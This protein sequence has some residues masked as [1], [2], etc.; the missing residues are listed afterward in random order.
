MTLSIACKSIYSISNPL[1]R[2]LRVYSVALGQAPYGAPD[3]FSFFTTDF[4]PAGDHREAALISPEAE[5]LTMSTMVTTQ[6]A[7]YALVQFGLS[8]CDGGIGPHWGRGVNWS[9]GD[10][11]LSLKH[12]AGFLGFTPTGDLSSSSNVVDQ[13]ATILTAGRLSSTNRQLIEE[14]YSNVYSSAQGREKEALQV[15]QVLIITSP[16]FNTFN[17]VVTDHNKERTPTP[18]AEKD[19]NTEYK[20]IIHLNLFGGM[21]SMNMIVPDPECSGLYGDYI[22]RRGDSLAL[23]ISELKSIDASSSNQPCSKF[24]V[25]KQ[26]TDLADIYDQGDGLFIANIGHLQKV[27]EACFVQLCS[28]FFVCSFL[29]QFMCQ[30]LLI[31]TITLQKQR[32][33][34]SRI[35]QCKNL[36]HFVFN[37]ATSSH[38]SL[39]LSFLSTRQEES[40]K[41]DAFNLMDNTGILGRM[42]DILGNSMAIGQVRCRHGTF[43]SH[44][45]RCAHLCVLSTTRFRSQS[46][47]PP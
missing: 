15:A 44:S 39:S 30:S 27:R 19:D 9:C 25:N 35:T 36:A 45:I 17:K 21:D 3:Q 32:H 42:N 22:A 5:L 23:T 8:A 26:L 41:V 13:L 20:A 47:R 33:S 18:P 6:N 40:F 38:A 4:S 14:A 16:E 2:P 29:T 11:D 12:S 10:R 1:F 37:D 7:L 24:A 31:R 34:F 28:V 43:A 46:T